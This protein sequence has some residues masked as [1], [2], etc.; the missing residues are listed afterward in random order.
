MLEKG[1]CGCRATRAAQACASVDA[2]RLLHRSAR[3]Q[4][5]ACAH[6]HRC[7]P[8]S[9]QAAEKRVGVGARMRRHQLTSMNMA[10]ASELLH[11]MLSSHAT[12]LNERGAALVTDLLLDLALLPLPSF[13][14]VAPACARAEGC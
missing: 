2:W 11:A 4:L 12:L 7:A 14:P 10:G 5:L 8:T 3:R 13:L 6:A 1:I 9:R